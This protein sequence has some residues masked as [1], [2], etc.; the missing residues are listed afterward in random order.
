MLDVLPAEK[1]WERAEKRGEETKRFEATRILLQTHQGVPDKLFGI[2]QKYKGAE[3]TYSV[4]DNDVEP[5]EQPVPTARF[6]C[7]DQTYEILDERRFSA[8]LNK[9]NLDVEKSLLKGSCA[10]NESAS[11]RLKFQLRMTQVGYRD[12]AEVSSVRGVVRSIIPSVTPVLAS[13][14]QIVNKR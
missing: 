6:N 7:K 10:Y 13:Q 5:G 9:A 12:K 8:F 3:I 4:Y 2:L 11:D 14:K 1:A